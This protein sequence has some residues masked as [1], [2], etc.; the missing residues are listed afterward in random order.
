MKVLIVEPDKLPYLKDIRQDLST[1]REIVGGSIQCTY[2]FEDM[3]GLVCNDEG[4]LEGLPL[5]RALRTRDGNIYDIVAGTFFIC[6]LSEEDFTDLSDYQAA[7]FY[8][9]FKSPEVH[10]Y[11]L[12]GLETKKYMKRN[13][14]KELF[15][16]D[17]NETIDSIL[18][19]SGFK[20]LNS[21]PVH[22]CTETEEKIHNKEIIG[23]L[24]KLSDISEF[25]KSVIVKIERYDI[26]KRHETSYFAFADVHAM[27]DFIM[28]QYDIKNGMDIG[29][30]P[31]GGL[32]MAAYGSGYEINH[33]YDLIKHR[34][35]FHPL[36]FTVDDSIG[37]SDWLVYENTQK[38]DIEHELEEIGSRA[39]EA[40]QRYSKNKV[41][42]ERSR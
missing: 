31:D 18:E 26:A 42:E 4:K 10:F 22:E 41:K 34:M 28:N 5:N 8:E 20:L 3:V 29:I 7:K 39:R 2:P 17:E 16:P 25:E 36:D 40:V 32:A 37:F 35:T 9:R 19:R 33:H 14:E 27:Q 1:Y 21:K 24:E 23:M 38:I 11:G 13:I 6:G 12:N 30:S 15:E